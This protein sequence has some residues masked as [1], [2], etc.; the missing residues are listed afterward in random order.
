M[1]R[2]TVFLARL[3]GLG[4][5]DVREL[6]AAGHPSEG[7][8][9]KLNFFIPKEDPHG[10]TL[11][12]HAAQRG[13]FPLVNSLFSERMGDTLK[14]VIDN[15]GRSALHL[16]AGYGHTD[17]VGCLLRHGANIFTMH[18]DGPRRQSGE[19][20]AFVETLIAGP[21]PVAHAQ[22]VRHAAWQA[23]LVLLNRVR[24]YVVGVVSELDRI[25]VAQRNLAVMMCTNQRLGYASALRLLEPSLFRQFVLHDES[26]TYDGGGVGNLT[27]GVLSNFIKESFGPGGPTA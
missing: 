20:I 7:V 3:M 2:V 23:I 22:T 14:D 12:H 16:A 17:V 26:G 21:A 4:V 27:P 11:L 1:N 6:A 19:V 25:V 15:R 9:P 10:Q 5:T 8:R 13:D 18:A 24:E